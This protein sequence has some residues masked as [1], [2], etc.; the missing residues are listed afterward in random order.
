MDLQTTHRYATTD[1]LRT[2]YDGAATRWH[3]SI[4]RMGV[5]GA[6]RHLF[7]QLRQMCRLE[8]LNADSYVLDA[9]IGTG[10]LSLALVE[11][12]TSAPCVK[13]VDISS[14]MLNQAAIHLTSANVPN[15]MYLRDAT[16]LPF[17]NNV[18]SMAMTAHMLE[19]MPNPQVALQELMRVL[20]P[21]APLL[22]L[23][24]RHGIITTLHKHRWHYEPIPQDDMLGMMTA[25][26]I[27]NICMM[28]YSNL[29]WI[30]NMSTALV[31][32]KRP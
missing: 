11:Q 24:S 27:E 17:R 6:Y 8:Q 7:A 1:A 15:K 28:P 26:G 25:V 9:G 16:E 18:F 14:A 5:T 13:G 22:V 4:S 10:A 3:T 21:G 2:L 29:P 12:C 23:T 30:R 19:H 20:R 31:G 32:T